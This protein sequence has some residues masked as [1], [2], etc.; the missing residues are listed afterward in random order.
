MTREAKKLQKVLDVIGQKN[1]IFIIVLPSFFDL[2]KQIA[3][4]RSKF[5]LHCY[6]DNTLQRGRFTYFGER[7]KKILYQFAGTSFFFHKHA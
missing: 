2:N 6:T 7:K 3:I 5:L 1:M 4:R